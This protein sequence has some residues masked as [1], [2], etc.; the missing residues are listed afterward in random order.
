MIVKFLDLHQQYLK[1]KDE[2]DHA[3]NN[4][5]SNTSF[6]GG[7]DVK[8]FELEFARYQ[9]IN[10]CIAVAN[11]TDALEIALESLDLPKNSEIIVPVNTFI[12]TSEAVTRLGHKVIFADIDVTSYNLD[13]TDIRAKITDKTSA[14]I[15]VHLYGNP[16]NMIDILEIC[17]SYRLKLIEDCSQAHGAKYNDQKVGSF[18]D[19]STFSFYPGKNLGA[20]GDAGAILTNN[21]SLADRCRLIANHGRIDKYN[22]IIEG[23]NSRLDSIQAAVLNVKLKY[24]DAWIEKRNIVAKHYNERLSEINNIDIPDVKSNDRH[25]Y[26][27]YVI[28]SDRRDGLMHYLNEHNV[29]TGIHYPTSLSNLEAYK[30]LNQAN[31]TPVANILQSRILSLPIGEHITIDHIDYTSDLIKKYCNK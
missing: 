24:L 31:T 2:I 20:Y 28:R 10:N 21:Q 19:I 26:H 3:I 5:I 27:L 13:I 15:A 23:R 1:I 22:H 29:E 30:Y 4:V 8:N 25:S 14:I 11:G 16:C 18:G 9:E 17:N 6:I 7:T 12:A